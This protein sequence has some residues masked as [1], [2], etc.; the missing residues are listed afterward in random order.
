MSPELAVVVAMVY[1]ALQLVEGYV[2]VPIVM[3]NTVGLSPFLVLASLL[4]GGAVAG[5]AG[6]FLAV[7]IVAAV[8]IVAARFQAREVPVLQDV[9]AVTGLDEPVAEAS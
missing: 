4:F 1:V 7:P 3:R 9:S 5:V 8:E 6:A 2:L